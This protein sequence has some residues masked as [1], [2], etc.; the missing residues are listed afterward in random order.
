MS[1]HI[2]RTMILPLALAATLA[3]AA[4]IAQ[5]AGQPPMPPH[6]APMGTRLQI[7]AQGEVRRTP[8]VAQVTAGVVTQAATAGQAMSENAQRMSAVI[9]A[10]KKAGVESR[11]IQ[12]SSLNLNPQYRYQENQPPQLIG[13][14]AT[15]T[16]QVTFRK[17]GDTGRVIDALVSQGANQINGP[18]L[19]I[20]DSD[21]AL[22]EARMQAMATARARAELYARAAG[23]HVRRIV[24]ISESGT[25]TPPRPYPMVRMMAAEAKA[26]TPVEAGE[27]ALSVNIDVTFEL[28]P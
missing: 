14:Q 16:V 1:M 9:A 3:P 23:M 12:T 4:A 13:Y 7:S 18:T 27:T 5:P 25:A 28:E 8:D 22:D 15:N 21:A 24:S 20:A 10:L 17:I 19:S 11:D 26:P 2:N 6:M